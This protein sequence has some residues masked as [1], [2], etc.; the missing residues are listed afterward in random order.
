MVYQKFA[1][2]F[3]LIDQI[4]YKII[5]NEFI[6]FYLDKTFGLSL[7]WPVFILAYKIKRLKVVQHSGL[8]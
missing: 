4:V 8:L 6:N 1:F 2:N 7:N 3:T 5:T